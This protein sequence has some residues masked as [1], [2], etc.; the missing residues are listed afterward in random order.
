MTQRKPAHYLT[1]CSTCRRDYPIGQL[2]RIGN[3]PKLR[4]ICSTC[5]A[6][7]KPPARG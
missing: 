5:N 6:K 2:K 3:G 4:L 7:R 1:S